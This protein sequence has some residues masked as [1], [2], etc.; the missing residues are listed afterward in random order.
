M[1]H[2]SSENSEKKMISTKEV[3]NRGVDSSLLKLDGS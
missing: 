2:A 3:C 1:K